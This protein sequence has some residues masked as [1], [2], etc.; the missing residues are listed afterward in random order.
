MRSAALDTIARLPHAAVVVYTDGSVLEPERL[1]KGGGGYIMTDASGNRHRGKCAAGARCT[2]FVAE[3]RALRKVLTDLTALDTGIDVPAGAEIRIGL[4]SQS[5]IRALAKGPSRQT[6]MLEM[7]VWDELTAVS[8]RHRAHLTVQYIPG[9]VK[10]E[11]QE[12]AD[13]IAKD[14][15]KECEQVNIPT[16]Y[17]MARAALWGAQR[18][19]LAASLPPEHL[20]SQS[21]GGRPPALDH[22]LP[23]EAQRRL[24]Q[25]RTGHS[26]II[27]SWLHS[28]SSR[29]KKLSCPARGDAALLTAGCIIQKVAPKTAAAAAGLREGWRVERIDATECRTDAEVR[30]A[31][32]RA[33]G[34]EV[35]MT[36][37]THLSPAC[38]AGCGAEEDSLR[39]LIVE[40]PGY[41]LA[42][43]EVFA[44]HAPPL[45][46]LRDRPHDVW[47]YLTRIGRTAPAGDPAR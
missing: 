12:E 1:G 15:A 5:A 31:L 26:P 30:A 24:A 7:A 33:K 42:R 45:T 39:H 29:K 40:C 21:T 25:L 8:R 10:V 2:S 20:W 6:G 11:G 13:R 43:H 41:A 19:K 44:S 35:K 34:K 3:L 16:T 4:D 28:I 18:G 47:R 22:T 37:R 27:A 17:E 14:A 32:A 9:H 46:V 23:R 36:V 38:P